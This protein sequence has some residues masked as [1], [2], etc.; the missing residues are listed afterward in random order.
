MITCWNNACR[1]RTVNIALVAIT[2]LNIYRVNLHT[3]QS[4]TTFLV[5]M[6]GWRASTQATRLRNLMEDLSQITA[7]LHLSNIRNSTQLMTI[8]LQ[9]LPLLKTLS[10]DGTV[11][12]PLL[13]KGRE[14]GRLKT[15]RLS[16][17]SNSL[18]DMRLKLLHNCSHLPLAL[19]WLP[20]LQ[21]T[22]HLRQVLRH[23]LT[24]M[25]RFTME[26]QLLGR[27]LPAR[28]LS[29]KP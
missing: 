29:N 27:L 22:Q 12:T 16:H 8:V 25:L 18:W 21:V 7:M 1:T 20:Q 2:C 28:H 15:Q 14:A 26:M 24:Q 17:L 13:L 4:L 5:P 23:P 3:R 9:S 11:I 10:K 19:A 6:V